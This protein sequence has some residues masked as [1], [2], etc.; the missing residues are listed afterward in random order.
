MTGFNNFGVN[1]LNLV[2]MF[3]LLG[4]LTVGFIYIIKSIFHPGEKNAWGVVG[5]IL[6]ALVAAAILIYAT[7]TSTALSDLGS[8]LWNN[9]ITMFNPVTPGG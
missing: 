7:T 9:L 8:V 5:L 2:I 1:A 3:G 4:I 6:A